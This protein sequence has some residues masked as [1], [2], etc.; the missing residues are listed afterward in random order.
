MTCRQASLFCVCLLLGAVTTLAVAWSCATWSDLEEQTPAAKLIQAMPDNWWLR[1]SR[2]RGFGARR[3]EISAFVARVDGSGDATST[4]LTVQESG[5][6]VTV[7][8]L[9]G[10]H[11][12]ESPYTLHLPIDDPYW[13]RLAD[14]SNFDNQSGDFVDEEGAFGWPML[15]MWCSYNTKTWVIKDD[16]KR[17]WQPARNGSLL[18]PSA[19]LQRLLPTGLGDRPLPLRPIVIGFAGNTALYSF[20]WWFAL[21]V[22]KKTRRWRRR[23][24]GRCEHCAYDLRGTS[25]DRCPECG[26]VSVLR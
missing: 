9:V 17:T 8:G 16:G 2:H 20:G 26:N 3:Y 11:L 14:L 13:S 25:S 21:F 4:H 10:L 15:A 1:F 18:Q 24:K 22:A 12:I 5:G 7:S 19:S 23:A 6:Y